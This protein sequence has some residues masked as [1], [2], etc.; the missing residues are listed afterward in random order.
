MGAR[1]DLLGFVCGGLFWV[2]WV[3]V[4]RCNARLGL[5]EDLWGMS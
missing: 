1:Y 2:V 4:V 3:G 5:R